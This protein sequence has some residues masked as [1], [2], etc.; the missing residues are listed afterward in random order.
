MK[1]AGPIVLID[2]DRDDL[3]I[4]TAALDGLGV[5]DDIRTFETCPAALDYLKNT[6][7]KPF[8]I[9]CDL[10][11]P[12]MNGLEF[13]RIINQN[14]FL[15]RKSIPFIFLSTSAIKEQVL[16][17]YELTV[18]GFF[19]KNFSMKDLQASLSCAIAYWSTCVH[20]NRV[21]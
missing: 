12:G 19:I 16:E 8:L 7:E 2:D 4:L 11:L 6:A 5:K 13:R 3:D 14:D 15:R 18:Q 9:F 21:H 10:N 1:I 20:P 17:A